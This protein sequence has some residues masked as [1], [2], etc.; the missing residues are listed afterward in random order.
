MR[1][2]V[3]D[4]VEVLAE[5]EARAALQEGTADQAKQRAQRARCACASE[6]HADCAYRDHSFRHEIEEKR[7]ELRKLVGTRY[8][9]LIG[10]F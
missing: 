10:T 2:A 7:Q 1:P 9:D 6:K 5:K 3:E 4:A 8:R